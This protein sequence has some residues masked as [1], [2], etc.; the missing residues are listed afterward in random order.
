MDE[1]KVYKDVMPVEEITY[2]VQQPDG[3]WRR[4]FT[5]DDL[6]KLRPIAE[7]IA[8]LEGNAFFTLV[9]DCYHNYLQEADAVYRSN[10]G[11]DGHAGGVSWIQDYRMIQ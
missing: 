4:R 5:E 11:D 3:G 10:G 8:M 9:E 2:T 1:Y 6:R 7:T